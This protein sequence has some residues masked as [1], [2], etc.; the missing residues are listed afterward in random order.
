MIEQF[1]RSFRRIRFYL[2]NNRAYHTAEAIDRMIEHERRQ[3]K[4]PA[5]VAENEYSLD[6]DCCH[7]Y[8]GESGND[9]FRGGV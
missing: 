1:T 6:N 4:K 5:V 7:S 3:L 8:K 2:Q 9:Y